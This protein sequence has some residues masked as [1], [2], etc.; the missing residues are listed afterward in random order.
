M[1]ANKNR[2]EGRR[3]CAGDDA[4]NQP[5]DQCSPD[6]QCRHPANVDSSNDG[7]GG[8]AVNQSYPRP[9]RE[10]KNYRLKV[11][12]PAFS[13]HVSIEEFLDWLY[14]VEKS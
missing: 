1:D 12:I 5:A 11:D 2:N 3:N 10:A 6:N 8:F 9:H 13:G 7:I 14:E 4:R